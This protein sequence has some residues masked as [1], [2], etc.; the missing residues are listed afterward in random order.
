M[1]DAGANQTQIEYWNDKSGGKWVRH[2]ETLDRQIGPHGATVIQ[3]TAIKP[4]EA[5]LDVGCGCGGTT[6]EIA[7]EVGPEGRVTGLDISAPMLA[8]ARERA[9]AQAL[10]HVEFLQGDAQVFD[11]PTAT[12]DA[13]V[14]RFG[15]MF[16]DDP[17]AAFSNIRRAL[18]PG[19]RLAFACWRPPQ[20]NPWVMLPMMEASKHVAMPPAPEPGEPGPFAFG[21]RL[22]V[23]RIL[24]DAGF[25]AIAVEKLDVTM[26]LG[27]SADLDESVDFMFEIG[28]MSRL[29]AEIDEPTHAKLRTA[30]RGVLE[31]FHGEQG[32]TMPSAAW[33]VTARS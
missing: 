25:D 32:V 17:V 16:F 4:G 10:T 14:S 29:V 26:A 2:Q 12:Y 8:R 1:T 23:K 22:R 21:D 11:L 19:G 15:I 9:S 27:P 33:V 28:P 7:R 13:A 30:I 24:S 3:A 18:K 5:V 31:Q 6:F 20:E